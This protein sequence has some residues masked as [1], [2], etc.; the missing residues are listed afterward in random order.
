MSDELRSAAERFAKQR[1]SEAYPWPCEMSEQPAQ[2]VADMALLAR[3]YLAEHPADDGEPITREWM[4]TVLPTDADS[5]NWTVRQSKPLTLEIEYSG[6]GFWLWFAHAEVPP[7]PV[8]QVRT[9][10]QLRR[11]LELLGIG[12]E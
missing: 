8:C 5:G 2:R 4:N 9:R 1:P 11:L 7:V 10:G 3:A 12:R 6:G